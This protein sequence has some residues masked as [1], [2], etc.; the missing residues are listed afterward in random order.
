MNR[1]P[2]DPRW[3]GLAALLSAQDAR[4]RRHLSILLDQSEHVDDLVQETAILAWRAWDGFD[5]SG[6]RAAWLLGIATFAVR[7]HRAKT[8]LGPAALAEMREWSDPSTDP[9]W[10]SAPGLAEMDGYGL[11]LIRWEVDGVEGWGH[12][13]DGFGYQSVAYAFPA[14][15]TTFVLLANGSSFVA[16]PGNLSGRFDRARDA[17]VRSALPR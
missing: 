11:G 4:L 8:L 1:E 5:G 13:G 12:N 10:A 2:H 16:E 6:T 7:N 17:L 3:L 9:E 15:D 14:V